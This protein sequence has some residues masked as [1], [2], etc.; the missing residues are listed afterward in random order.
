MKPSEH[1]VKLFHFPG[2]VTFCAFENLDPFLGKSVGLICR[3][4]AK[5]QYFIM[6]AHVRIISKVHNLDFTAE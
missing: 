3:I 5:H 2:L 4:K 6:M 1:A